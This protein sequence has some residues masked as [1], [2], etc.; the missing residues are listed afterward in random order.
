MLT[1]VLTVVDKA[2]MQLSSMV[3]PEEPSLATLVFNGLNLY[4][5][6][7]CQVNEENPHH[8][9]RPYCKFESQEGTTFPGKPIMYPYRSRKV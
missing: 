9:H 5:V 2:P 1:F 8:Y 4:S 7:Y 3:M 6:Y